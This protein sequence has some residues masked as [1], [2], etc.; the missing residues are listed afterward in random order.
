MERILSM[1]TTEYCNHCSG[2]FDGSFLI[3]I[4]TFPLCFTSYHTDIPHKDP[5]SKYD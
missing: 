4:E 5:T 3:L 2:K 1:N